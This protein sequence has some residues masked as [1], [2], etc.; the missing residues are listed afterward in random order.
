ML[1]LERS[2]VGL[3][4]RASRV[5]SAG[6]VATD[7]CGGLLRLCGVFGAGA[8]DLGGGLSCGL[9]DLLSGE[10]GFGVERGG[11]M[12]TTLRHVLTDPDGAALYVGAGLVRR[13]S[14]HRTAG[15]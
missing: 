11:G 13:G 10:L 6:Q 7:L 15:A 1:A 9:L 12:C 14:E 8:I 2:D 5:H 3:L 4:I